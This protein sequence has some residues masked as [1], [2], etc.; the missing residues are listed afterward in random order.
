TPRL[1]SAPARCRSG[2]SPKSL[3]PFLG[4]VPRWPLE[5]GPLQASCWDCKTARSRSVSTFIAVKWIVSPFGACASIFPALH[6]LT[7]CSLVMITPDSIRK[8]VPFFCVTGQNIRKTDLI[9]A[10][11]VAPAA[12][13]VH[14]VATGTPESED[15]WATPITSASSARPR[16]TAAFDV[17]NTKHSLLAEC[18]NRRVPFKNAEVLRIVAPLR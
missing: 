3:P 4:S 8:P 13:R 5:E 12:S 1:K 11:W 9:E 7:T 14:C 2:E 6:P 17:D 15:T 18:R 10:R 16:P